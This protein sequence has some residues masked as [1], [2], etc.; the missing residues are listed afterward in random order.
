MGYTVTYDA[1]LR[2]IGGAQ[3][4]KNGANR[5][6]RPKS[7]APNDHWP[8]G[9]VDGFVKI[10]MLVDRTSIE[11]FPNDGEHFLIHGGHGSWIQAVFQSLTSVNYLDIPAEKQVLDQTGLSG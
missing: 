5:R 10:D 4:E 9:T 2:T 1:G 7:E 3:D 8:I 11:L 6:H